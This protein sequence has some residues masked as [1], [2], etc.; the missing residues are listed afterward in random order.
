MT[1]DEAY[2]TFK[3]LRWPDGVPTCPSCGCKQSWELVKNRKW[4]CKEKTC[5]TQFTVTSKTPLASR[6]L[7]YRDIL[8]AIATFANGVNGVASLR[9]SRE[10]DVTY[11]T[12]FVLQHKIREALGIHDDGEQ[13]EG[14]VEI[15]G[16]FM[17]SK[18]V[19]LR[20]E[21]PNKKDWLEYI[22]KHPKKH[23]SLVVLRE[24]P[25]PD[26]TSR[27]RIR[28]THT[29]NEGASIPFIRKNV[30]KGTVLQADFGGQWEG[31][32][33]LYKMKRI[34]HSEAFSKDGACTNLAES[35]FSRVRAAERGVYKYWTK[36][37]VEKYGAELAWREENARVSNGEQIKLITE[38]V[39]QSGPSSM[40]GYWQRHNPKKGAILNTIF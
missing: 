34:N 25:S 27:G 32:T 18:K 9:T 20:N 37:Y 23:T 39:M 26:G 22:K 7:E 1:E 29:P 2:E 12:A 40:K 4:K 6:K 28:T 21:I 31:L 30:K 5:R 8:A 33:L 3:A 10:L 16:A 35:F 36:A 17:G 38:K 24:R 11:K 19:R 14:E 15:D 13:L